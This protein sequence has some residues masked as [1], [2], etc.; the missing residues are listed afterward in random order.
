M[1]AKASMTA[2]I[3]EGPF[4][5]CWIPALVA[6]AILTPGEPERAT[7]AKRLADG[8]PLPQETWDSIVSSARGVGLEQARI[9][10]VA[11]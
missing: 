10:A 1:H 9:A 4:I 3:G 5:A 6:N 8:I 11:R 2:R 7:R